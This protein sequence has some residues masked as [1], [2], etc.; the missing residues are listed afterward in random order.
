MKQY[1]IFVLSFI[2][3]SILFLL[4]L[5][6]VYKTPNEPSIKKYQVIS[7]QKNN[8]LLSVAFYIIKPL[9]ENYIDSRLE[10]DIFIKYIEKQNFLN[11]AMNITDI[12]IGDGKS[13][14]CGD[15]VVIS[16]I[17]KNNIQMIK[18]IKLGMDQEDI[19]NVGVIGMKK[20]GIRSIDF[21]ERIVV[22]M[23]DVTDHLHENLD[24]MQI[25]SNKSLNKKAHMCG[26]TIKVHYKIRDIY[27]NVI[28]EN[29]T[30]FRI[31]SGEV[32]IA[33]EQGSI[34]IQEDNTKIVLSPKELLKTTNN[35]K[36]EIIDA[37]K[38]VV[39]DD[40]MYVIEITLL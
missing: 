4:L 17:D 11:K 14:I 22:D 38:N 3:L 35:M 27:K 21:R 23:L 40:S 24:D 33:I 37:F 29:G 20:G 36:K 1:K 7:E 2:F 25:F 10:K 31:G 12:K 6:T 26:E 18:T 5:F 39:L 34:E 32:P 30:S 15:T 16:I 9:I 13:T 28:L 19:I 8:I